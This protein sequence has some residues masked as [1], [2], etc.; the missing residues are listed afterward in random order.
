[1]IKG[2]ENHDQKTSDPGWYIYSRG[3]R[4]IWVAIRTTNPRRTKGSGIDACAKDQ[5]IG[6]SWLV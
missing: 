6:L 2:R 4:G 1:M 5:A 3:T